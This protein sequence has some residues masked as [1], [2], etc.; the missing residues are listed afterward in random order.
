ME[1]NPR[2][3]A[4][5]DEITRFILARYMPN[6]TAEALLLDD[7]LFEGGII[8]SGGA[9]EFVTFLERRYGFRVLDDELFR[10]NF[11]TVARV[12]AFVRRKLDQNRSAR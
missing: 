2:C 11:A 6:E 1:Q 9:L 3:E 8:D 4:V 12:A 10:E 5:E 7:L